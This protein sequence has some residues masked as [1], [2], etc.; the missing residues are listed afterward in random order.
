MKYNNIVYLGGT[1]II[2]IVST[3]TYT[4]TVNMKNFDSF[5]LHNVVKKL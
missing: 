1:T 3:C 5:K 4:C 2:H